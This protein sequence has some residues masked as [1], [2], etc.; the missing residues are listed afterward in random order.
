MWYCH[1]QTST[2]FSSHMPLLTL[3]WP[4]LAFSDV[5]SVILKLRNNVD[6]MLMCCVNYVPKWTL[7]CHKPLEEENDKKGKSKRKI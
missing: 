2:L 5:N 7:F 1:T 6:V 3:S 4:N